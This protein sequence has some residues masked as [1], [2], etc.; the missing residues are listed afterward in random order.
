M[1][2]KSEKSQIAYNAIIQIIGRI[3]FLVLSLVNIKLITSYLS[4]QGFGEYST[5]LTFTGFFTVLIDLGLFTVAV[6]EISKA[7]ERSQEILSNIM[8]L[9]LLT[10]LLATIIVIVIGFAI[11]KYAPLGSGIIIAAVAMFFYF[12][13]NILDV[14]FH[15]NLKMQYISLAENISKIVTLFCVWIAVHYNLGVGGILVAI[16]LGNMAAM[17]PRILIAQNF[18]RI[19]LAWDSKVI[20]WLLKLSLPLA[21][22]FILNNI[23]FKIDSQ[24]LYILST[25]YDAG[26]YGLVYR[27]METTLFVATFIIAAITP[28]LSKYI[29]SDKAK[30]QELVSRS[31]EVL[32][33]LSLL[34]LVTISIFPGQ[35]IQFLSDSSFLPAVP[36]M[37]ILAGVAA[38]MYINGLFGQILIAADK[39]K[40]M[41]G[42]SIFLVLFNIV[43]NFILIPK[44]GF[45]G[46]AWST[47]ISE[48][49]VLFFNALVTRRIV[50]LQIN[51]PRI[52]KLLITT[53]VVAILLYILKSQLHWIVSIIIGLAIYIF[54]LWKTEAFS[55]RTLRS[56]IKSS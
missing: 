37:S 56:I 13:S 47:L 44:Y 6:R 14:V 32:L 24:M 19:K 18:I 11:P 53:I 23:Y 31:F 46:A 45:V 43:L 26:L 33:A 7:H 52:V 2:N 25:T 50:A 41:V 40:V 9:R 38:L 39:R 30:A 36:A 28:S 8:S 17:A 54:I 5:I 51:W 15:V 3:F 27:I 20:K 16:L 22:V 29:E 55:P 4:P 35:I 34:L 1:I 10:A 21:L 48:F 12:I 42:F 49:A